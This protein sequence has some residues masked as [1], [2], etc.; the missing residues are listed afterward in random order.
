VQSTL[1]QPSDIRSFFMVKPNFIVIGAMKCATSTVCAYLEDHPDVFMV[2]NGEPNFFSHDANWAKGPE[3]YGHFFKS[4]GDKAL[5]GEG[6]NDYTHDAIYPNSAERMAKLYPDAKLIYMVRH[7]VQRIVASWI[8]KRVDQRDQ[9]SPTLDRAIS[10]MP[11]VF[12]DESL[13]WRQISRYRAHFPDGRIFIGFMEDLK[14]DAPAFMARLCAFLEIAPTEALKRPHMNPSTGKRAPSELYSAVRRLPGVKA[15]VGLVPTGPK[16]WLRETFFSKKLDDLPSFSPTT[17]ARL[18][19]Q[20]APDTAALLV[21]CN[22][23][24]EHWR[25]ETI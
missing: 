10:E 17:L 3:W 25:F 7:P 19:A 11:D 15:L 8:Q 12:V 6:S 23:P 2:S 20:L 1:T 21:H 4:R 16:T 18:E 22:K 13:Y 5:C 9:V 24:A 14:S